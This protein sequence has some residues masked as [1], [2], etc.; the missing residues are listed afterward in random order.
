M[1]ISKFDDT[2]IIIYQCLHV[3]HPSSHF[4]GHFGAEESK[5]Q[6]LGVEP[7]EI[8]FEAKLKSLR[9]DALTC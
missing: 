6:S 4:N 2:F 7:E 9:R 3:Y 8:G 1:Y 5:L